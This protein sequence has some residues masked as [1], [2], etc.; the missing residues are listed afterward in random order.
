VAWW[1]LRTFWRKRSRYEGG[2]QGLMQRV[3]EWEADELRSQSEVDDILA[4]QAADR[5]KLILLIELLQKRID[6]A[7]EEDATFSNALTEVERAT[8]LGV[9]VWR[10]SEKDMGLYYYAGQLRWYK[11]D[12]RIPVD[13]DLTAH[14]VL[15]MVTWIKSYT[16]VRMKVA[17]LAMRSV[18]G[19]G[20]SL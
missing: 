6:Q 2:I 1:Q 9:P 5:I 3:S 10:N 20:G 18:L 4:M 7:I 8:G 12:T 13:P 14:E 16:I 19:D 11:L 17:V 15:Q